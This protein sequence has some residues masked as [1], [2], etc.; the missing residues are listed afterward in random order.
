M[1][2]HPGFFIFNQKTKEMIQ[3]NVTLPIDIVLIALGVGIILGI[4]ILLLQKR[5]SVLIEAM[6]HIIEDKTDKDEI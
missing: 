2:L 5:N 1:F 3:G 4:W 6:K